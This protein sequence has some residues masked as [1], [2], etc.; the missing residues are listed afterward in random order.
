MHLKLQKKKCVT[1][2]GLLGKGGGR[3]KNYVE[4]SIIVPSKSTARIQEMHILIGHI[5]CDLIE[6][7]LDLKK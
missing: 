5:L 2:I 4:E 6:V 3:A 7:G 1:T